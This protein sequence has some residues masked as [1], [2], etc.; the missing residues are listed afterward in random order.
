MPLTLT[1]QVA[2]PVEPVTVAEAK[3]HLRL[4]TG[5]YDSRIEAFIAAAREQVERDTERTLI[6][7]TWQLNLDAFPLAIRQPATHGELERARSRYAPDLAKIKLPRPPLQSV[8]TVDY[9]DTGGVS[10]TLGS[11]KYD[12]DANSEPARL[13]EAYGESWPATRDVV[14]A[15]TIE[16]VAGFGDAEADVPQALREAILTVVETL[17][18]RPAGAEANAM[19]RLYRQL[20]DPFTVRSVQ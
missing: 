17:H 8:N 12:V 19:Q 20:V 6:T 5:D 18:D 10:Q 3:T 1:R 13:V 2:P 16:Y 7:T 15:V 4:D 9:I 14:N 11:S